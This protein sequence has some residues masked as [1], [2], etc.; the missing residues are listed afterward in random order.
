VRASAIELATELGPDGHRRVGPPGAGE[1]HGFGGE[2]ADVG[3]FVEPERGDV[4]G[5]FDRGAF[6]GRGGHGGASGECAG[7]LCREAPVDAVA[8]VLQGVL[9]LPDEALH[10]LG[11]VG[12]AGRARQF[13]RVEVGVAGEEVAQHVAELFAAVVTAALIAGAVGGFV[14]RV[15]GHDDY[16]SPSISA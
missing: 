14:G 16:A 7:L 12:Q 1:Q 4:Q 6:G 10:H 9:Q 2:A 5:L 13:G 3:G 15:L 8:A 11:V